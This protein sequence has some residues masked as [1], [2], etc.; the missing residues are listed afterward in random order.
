MGIFSHSRLSTFEQ[1]P[2]KYKFRYIDKIPPRIFSI[3]SHLGGS[4]HSS[5]EWLYIQVKNGKIPS[6][7]ELIEHYSKEWNKKKNPDLAI[8]D[9]SLTEKDYFNKGVK[10]LIDYYLKNKPFNDNTIEVEK[11]VTIALD[12]EGK[13]KIQ[14]FIDR[15]SYNKET[16]EYEIH[17]YKTSNSLPYREKIDNDRQLALYAIAVKNL[18]GR[19]KNVCLVWHYLAYNRKICSRRTDEQLEQ[20]KKDT[21]E[22]IKRIK[23]TTDFPAK[24]SVLCKWCEYR[25]ICQDFNSDI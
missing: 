14:G 20:L 2:L 21:I 11:K 15:L 23:S 18:Y 12:E 4:V 10:F 9:N 13:Y 19:D 5:L 3:E 16:D 8:A 1:C 7:E 6:V 22:L 25:D 17:D 24:K